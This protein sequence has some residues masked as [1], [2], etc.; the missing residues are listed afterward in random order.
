LGLRYKSQ[1]DVQTQEKKDLPFI[2]EQKERGSEFLGK[3][4]KE[5][6]Y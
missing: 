6:V 1:K 3:P 2:Q 4:T 5:E